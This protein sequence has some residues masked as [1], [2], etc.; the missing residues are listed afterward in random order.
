MSDLQEYVLWLA[1]VIIGA[2]IVSQWMDSLIVVSGEKVGLA[3]GLC[4]CMF[5]ASLMFFLVR[6]VIIWLDR[7]VYIEK[8]QATKALKTLGSA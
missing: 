5:L 2:V 8:E 4:L 7:Q 3:A 6:N 1:L